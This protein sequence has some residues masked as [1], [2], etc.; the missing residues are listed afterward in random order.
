MILAVPLAEAL[1][2]KFKALAYIDP[3]DILG[4]DL[5]LCNDDVCSHACREQKVDG[6]GV[7]VIPPY[8]GK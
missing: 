5:F 1:N 6:E 7:D 4:F 2:L 3:P 8:L